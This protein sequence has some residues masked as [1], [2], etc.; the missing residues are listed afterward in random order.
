[1][2]NLE[3]GFRFGIKIFAWKKGILGEASPGFLGFEGIYCLFHRFHSVMLVSERKFNSVYSF[4]FYKK[5]G[6][7]EQALIWRVYSIC[8]FSLLA[9]SCFFFGIVTS[10]TPFLYF[11]VAFFESTLAGSSS[12]LK[13]FR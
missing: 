8:M 6:K 9:S 13:Y 4:P 12:S 7:N 1:M 5:E 10:K 2:L 3:T 11:D